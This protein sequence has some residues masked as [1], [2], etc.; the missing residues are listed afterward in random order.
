L[1]A[2][3]LGPLLF[4]LS[5]DYTESYTLPICFCAFLVLV[6]S[7]S[8]FVVNLPEQPEIQIETAFDYDSPPEDTTVESTAIEVDE[9]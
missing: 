3:G 5:K 4:G 2:S 6:V 8:L 1:V 7:S 9:L